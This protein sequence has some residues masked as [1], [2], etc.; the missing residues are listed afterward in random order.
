MLLALRRVDARVIATPHPSSGLSCRHGT[1]GQHQGAQSLLPER[2]QVLRQRGSC[3]RRLSGALEDDRVGPLAEQHVRAVRQAHQCRHALAGRVELVHRQ[4]L[5]RQLATIAKH[6]HGARGAADEPVAE[7][8][9]GCCERTLVRRLRLQRRLLALPPRLAASVVSASRAG[10][11]TTRGPAMVGSHALAQR[12]ATPEHTQRRIPTRRGRGGR[13]CRGQAAGAA[14]SGGGALGAE[15]R[16]RVGG[17]RDGGRLRLVLLVRV[18]GHHRVAGGHAQQEL[19]HVRTAGGRVASAHQLCVHGWLL[20]RGGGSGAGLCCTARER[21]RRTLLD[22]GCAAQRGGGRVRASQEDRRLICGLS[23]WRQPT[24]ASTRSDP[25]PATGSTA[26]NCSTARHHLLAPRQA[27]GRLRRCAIHT[28]ADRAH[29]ELHHILRQ[30]ACLVGEHVFDLTQVFV[31]VGGSRYSGCVR[32]LVVHL[33]VRAQQIRLHVVNHLHRHI[34]ADGDEIAV[35]DD[36]RHKHGKPVRQPVGLGALTVQ[37]GECQ[38]PL[39]VLVVRLPSHQGY[40]ADSTEYHLREHDDL[41]Q[42]VHSAVDARELGP[43]SR[44]LFHH[45]GLCPGE[46]HQA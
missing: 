38:L 20:A 24:S 43:C 5:Q 25:S 32:Q 7:S 14:E 27:L 37:V 16:A 9:G 42:P 29:L 34:Q 4:H 39:V 18:L 21:R 40:G 2:V 10:I 22:F 33:G 23:D 11:Q 31:E 3:R 8:P 41:D 45:L 30:G 35:Q 36:E 13:R 17:E 19:V 6:C 26:A 28:A 1:L 12:R 15:Q 44:G 46:H